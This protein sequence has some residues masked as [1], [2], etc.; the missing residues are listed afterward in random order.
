MNP[1][2]LGSAFPGQSPALSLPWRVGD[3]PPLPPPMK[4]TDFVRKRGDL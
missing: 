3:I 1:P 4:T 2:E